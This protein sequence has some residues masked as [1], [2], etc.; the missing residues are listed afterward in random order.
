MM[1]GEHNSKL[2]KA[3]KEVHKNVPSTVKRAGSMSKKKK[4]KMLRAIAFSKAKKGG[5]FDS[6]F[7]K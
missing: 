4:E 7:H 2:E 3:M 6:K 5:Y 1:H